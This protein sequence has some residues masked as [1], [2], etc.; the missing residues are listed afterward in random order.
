MRKAFRDAYERELSLLYE[1]GAEFAAEYP[2]IAG[3]LG[4]LLRDNADP[5]VAGLLEGA[6]FM[7]A[8]VHLKMDEEFRNFTT[9]LLDQVF[10]DALA[11]LPSMMLAQA[12]IPAD[13]AN[14]AE[15]LEVPVGAAMDA[16]FVDADHRVACRFTT[17][18]PLTIW[19]LRLGEIDYLGSA[20]ELSALGQ[21]AA[22]GALAGLSIALAVTGDAD[23][24][25]GELPVGDL[26]VHFTASM[27]DATA[28]YEQVHCDVVRASLR[29]LDEQGDPVIRRLP[30]G[31]IDQIGF[32]RSERILPHDLRLFDGFAL[33]REGFAFPRQFLG[34]RLRDA[35]RHLAG[36]AAREVQLILEFDRLDPGLMERLRPAHLRLHCVPAVNLFPESAQPIRLDGKRH[37]FVVTPASSPATHY[38]VHR[39][40]DV[41][42]HYGSSRARMPVH[43]LYGLP[44]DGASDPRQALYYTSRRKPRRLTEEERRFGR[45]QPYLGTETFL[46][47]WEPPDLD[48]GAD[49]AQG[50][51]AQRLHV[52]CLC[53]NRHLPA[54]LP[55]SDAAGAFTLLDD[56]TVTLAAV[57]G[58]TAPRESLGMLDLDAPHRAV[59]GDVQWRLLSYLS[60]SHFGIEDRAGGDSAAALREMLSLFADLSEATSEKQIGGIVGLETRPVTQLIAREDGHLPA[61]GIE[62]RITFDEDAYE[63]AGAVLMG[64]ILDRFLAEYAPTNSF[65]RTVVASRQRGDIKTWPARTGSGP[66]L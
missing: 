57:A 50:H 20:A 60:L 21:D 34:M 19:P 48:D 23:V 27:G 61:R 33:L 55:K 26:P 8:R 5:A 49:D 45:R 66:L 52:R 15:G 56:T 30:P 54:M 24:P 1:R 37:E 41:R 2:G 65:T 22:P 14:L 7:A 10:P 35:S 62:L 38:E 43:P 17:A 58:P 64:A 25:L 9:E 31:A 53:S 3:R 59:A 44:D 16:R 42:A 47:F 4:G 11:P 51:G 29:W 46:S 13:A 39:I 63:G 36:I 40:L 28:L 6:A 12:A 32:D 18:A